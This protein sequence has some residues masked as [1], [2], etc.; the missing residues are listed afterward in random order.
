MCRVG[1][2]IKI[3]SYI[4]D[5]GKKVGRHSF[6]VLSENKDYIK[7]L[8]FDLVGTPMSSIKDDAQRVKIEKD[9]RLMIIRT[10]DQNGMPASKYEESFIKANLMYY[11]ERKKVEYKVLGSLN[12]ETFM[13]LQQKL[14]DLDNKDK[15]KQVLDNLE[16][17][18]KV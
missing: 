9:E 18:T 12:V 11:F 4:G 6:V 14:S 17:Y 16:I 3:E 5:D 1:D 7:G 2:I 10:N 15:I 13:E 8:A